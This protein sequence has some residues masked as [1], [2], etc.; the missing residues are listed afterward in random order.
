MSDFYNYRKEIEKGRTRHKRLQEQYANYYK[1][2]TIVSHDDSE[3]F[4]KNDKY[5]LRF[6][7]TRA[8]KHHVLLSGDFRTKPYFFLPESRKSL[9]E[10]LVILS[11]Y[12]VSCLSDYWKR[13]SRIETEIFDV[14]KAFYDLYTMYEEYYEEE[15]EYKEK[16][17]DLME[18]L[19][20]S[21]DVLSL[22]HEASDLLGWEEGHYE[23]GKVED[24]VF[25][26]IQR[27]LQVLVEKLPQVI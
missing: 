4:L 16:I 1:T 15:D 21:G 11:G 22:H 27:V 25:Y 13:A 2:L 10:N 18:T 26:Q 12:H 20:Y 24:E 23:I 19:S 14:D 8:G 7:F 6:R 17:L 3:V 5:L 9:L